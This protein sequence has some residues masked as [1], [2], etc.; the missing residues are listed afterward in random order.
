MDNELPETRINLYYIKT[1]F[2]VI[3]FRLCHQLVLKRLKTLI[4][5]SNS[6]DQDDLDKFLWNYKKDSFLPHLT[7]NDEFFGNNLIWL[8]TN[9]DKSLSI[10]KFDVL[11]YAPKVFLGCFKKVKKN[12]FMFSYFR[13]QTDCEKNKINLSSLKYKVKAFIEISE[14]KWKEI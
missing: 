1:D 4:T 12:F 2:K 13:N 11:I 9:Q 3:I 5:L 6:Q 8:T 14:L 10:E 7:S